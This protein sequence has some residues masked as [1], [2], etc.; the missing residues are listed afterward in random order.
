MVK[1]MKRIILTTLLATVW[2]PPS[3]EPVGQEGYRVVQRENCVELHSP[4][5]VFRLDAG[6][7]AARF[8]RLNGAVSLDRVHGRP[9]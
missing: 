6:A 7:G 3:A 2:S 8:A 4:F 5:L 9:R 1:A